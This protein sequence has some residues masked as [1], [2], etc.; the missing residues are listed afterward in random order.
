MCKIVSQV[1]S[2]FE[3]FPRYDEEGNKLFQLSEAD[4][5]T[6]NLAFFKRNAVLEC[7]HP[8]N[9]DWGEW[10]EMVVHPGES[11][12]CPANTQLRIIES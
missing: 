8:E 4:T 2:N 3:F 7:R 11:L 5:V 9:G 1:I 10:H 6:P 12:E